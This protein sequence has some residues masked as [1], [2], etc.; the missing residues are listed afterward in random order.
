MGWM[1]QEATR[2]PG[3]LKPGEPDGDESRY[4]DAA[5]HRRQGGLM[6]RPPLHLAL[7]SVLTAAIDNAG[8]PG[9]LA[10]LHPEFGRS[11]ARPTEDETPGMARVIP[12]PRVIPMPRREPDPIPDPMLD[13]DPTSAA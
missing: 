12:L 2:S 3:G 8:R 5:P 7:S 4:Q 11:V 13:P 1:G 10:T 6:T 9:L